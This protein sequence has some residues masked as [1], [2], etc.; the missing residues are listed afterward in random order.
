MSHIEGGR[1]GLQFRAGTPYIP[2]LGGRGA[3]VDLGLAL[4]GHRPGTGM[5]TMAV[6]LLPN[7]RSH[8]VGLGVDVASGGALGVGGAL[9]HCQDGR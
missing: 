1:G 5:E 3:G 6:M 2:V 8:L 4:G 7:D 9:E